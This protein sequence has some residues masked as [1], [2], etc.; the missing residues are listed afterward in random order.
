MSKVRVA[1]F[2]LSI[3]GFG[4]GLEQSLNDPLGKRGPELF[5]WFFPTRTFQAM[6]GKEGETEG[7]DA[8]YAAS[9]NTDFGAFILGRNMFGPFRGEWPDE[10]WKGWWGDN[11]PYHAPTFILTHYPRAPI[12]ME[13]GTTFYFITGGI[14]E[15]LMQAKAAAGGKD[16]KIGGGV[17]TVRQYLQANLVD[18]IQYAIS[19]VVL[20]RGEAMFAG[21]DLPSLGFRVVAHEATEKATHIV[22][23][24]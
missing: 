3:D 20:G 7:A 16:I 12:V 5:E 4:A 1:G 18:E 8:K 23:R 22:L 6:F 24:K 19:P 21:I 11:P 2:S 13:G 17:S 14:E 10:N 9:A 15:A